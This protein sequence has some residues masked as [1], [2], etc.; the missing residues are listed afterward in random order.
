MRAAALAALVGLTGVGAPTPVQVRIEGSERTLFEGQVTT[1]ARTIDPGDGSGP[2]PCRGPNAAAPGPSAGSAL[3]DAGLPWRGTWYAD[4]RDVFV[5]AIGPDASRPPT[6]YWAVLVDWRYATGA[7]SQPVRPGADVLWAY[8][9]ASRTAMLRL[10][11]PS[12]APLGRPIQLAVEDAWVREDGSGG[13]PVSEARVAGATTDEHGRATIVFDRPGTYRLKA[14]HPRAVRSNALD[15]C[16]GPPCGAGPPI[17]VAP[18][19]P[20]PGARPAAPP[21]P[22]LRIVFPRDRSRLGRRAARRPIR[23]SLTGAPAGARLEVSLSGHRPAPAGRSRCVA[24]VPSRR[25]RRRPCRSSAPWV[26][27]RSQARWRLR[28]HGA[29][30][31]GRYVLRVRLRIGASTLGAARARFTVTAPP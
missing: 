14:E 5:E 6:G 25:L 11:G 20:P 10:R 31:P 17:E 18:A 8:G 9:A 28:L 13:G 22:Q 3:A 16:A 30:A 2:H 29:P 26:E 4:F 27:I 23:G 24:L 7:C 21:T 1:D 19:E 15:V 12:T